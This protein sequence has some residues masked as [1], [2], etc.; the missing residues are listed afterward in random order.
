[1]LNPEAIEAFNLAQ[2]RYHLQKYN[3]PTTGGPKGGVKKYLQEKL[4]AHILSLTN[5]T[6]SSDT[7]EQEQNNT[8][9]TRTEITLEDNLE[10]TSAV[11]MFKD[12]FNWTSNWRRNVFNVPSGRL[13]KEYVSEMTRL[14]EI[15]C[16]KHENSSYALYG[17]MLMP[18]LILQKPSKNVKTKVI[19]EVVERR[20]KKWK[21]CEYEYLYHEA[22]TIQSRLRDTRPRNGEK[23]MV[24]S[25]RHLM[26]AGKIRA[27]LKVIEKSSSNGIHEINDGTIEKLLLKHPKGQD[28]QLDM[29]LQGPIKA[30]N[31]VIYEEITSDLIKKMATRVKGT[32]GPSNMDADQWFHI[33]GSSAFGQQSDELAEAIA[34]MTKIL[35][36]E[37]IE[38]KDS[39]VPIMACR[40]IPLEKN[41]GIRPIGIGE[42]LRRIMG[43]AV[44][45]IFRE[46]IIE[47]AG[48][49]QSCAGVKGGIEANIHA[50]KELCEDEATEGLIQVDATNAFNLLNRKNMLM[51]IQI[52]CPEIATFTYNCYSLAAR[53]FVS[54]GHEI[55]SQEGVTQGCALSMPIYAL[56]LLP[57]MSAI[58]L[59]IEEN[60]LKQA[61]Y[62]DDLAGVGK[63]E[64]LKQWWLN[65]MDYGPKVGYYPEPS[66]S[67]LIVKHE[68]LNDAKKIFEGTGLNLT[69]EGRKHLGAAVG[70]TNFKEEYVRGKIEEWKTQVEILAKIAWVEPHLAYIAFVFGM[71]NKY[72][73]M[74][75]TL[76]NI[77][78]QLKTLD[79]SID[80]SLLVALFNGRKLN[81]E[82]RILVSLPTRL[83]GLGIRIPSEVSSAQYE[84]SVGITRQLTEHIV[85]QKEKLDINNEI[86][87]DIIQEA[88]SRK[89]ESNKVQF[90]KAINASNEI[91]ARIIQA[92]TEKGASAWLNALP[93]KT[94]DYHLSKVEFWDALYL[95]Y[96]FRISG[97]P[98]TCAC[99]NPYSISHSLT[100]LKGGYVTM[101]HNILRDTTADLLTITSKDVQIEPILTKLTGEELRYKTGKV[102][103]DARVDV[104]ARNFWRFGDKVFLDIRI[105]NPIADTHL[106]KSLKEAHE[107]NEQ[108]KKRQYNDRI[109]N[110]EHGFFTPLVFSCFGGMSHEC[111]MFF[112]HITNLIADKRN[113]TYQNVTR[114]IKTKISFAL[115]K[116]ALICLRGYR[117]KF[118]E[119][120]CVLDENIS[121][122]IRDCI[123]EAEP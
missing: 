117:G 4:K 53:M 21:E 66:K 109:Q 61:A 10:D 95:R 92:T 104:S 33:L 121:K 77:G 74:M 123:R 89:E 45:T 97:L 42:V 116:V 32:A 22:K 35:C 43:K 16:N 78:E 2:L 113:E 51:N 118:K 5:T 3:L 50:M 105:F 14:I 58:K 70:A 99:G 25:F 28:T 114:W 93:M 40:L 82:E 11:K 96:G 48:S 76:P 103:D 60:S 100:C 30:V 9:P 29:I 37:K 90:E 47:Q 8:T 75:R 27:A 87:K 52:L 67:W 62:A 83:G 122:D 56:G 80:D 84:N 106:K 12:I 13:G 65:L 79:K 111:K 19:K 44:L 107:A 64:S 86:I 17:L 24:E 98:T 88:K 112:K 59:G 38:D 69:V 72:T 54:G 119:K 102:E 94:K 120:E 63:L 39:L 1:M 81:E 85:L 7:G 34:K 6:Q 36:T 46:E 23:G 15:W 55:L 108:E 41:P 20:M 26:T 71:Q 115:L 101:R 57:L 73:Y 110:V 68:H 91:H 49:L 18:K 31:P